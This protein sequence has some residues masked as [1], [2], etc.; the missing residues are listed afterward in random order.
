MLT[1]YCKSCKRHAFE[2]ARFSFFENVFLQNVTAADIAISAIV[3]LIKRWDEN[4]LDNF[5]NVKA[6]K[7]AVEGRPNIAKWIEKRPKTDI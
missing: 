4:F 1:L 2:S 3:D 6:M 7:E 5:P